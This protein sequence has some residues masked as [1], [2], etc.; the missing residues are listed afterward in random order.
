MSNDFYREIT[1]VDRLIHE[2][3][4][5]A[6]M[7]LLYGVKEADFLFIQRHTGLTKGNLSVHL[8]KL[9]EAGYV[10]IEKRFMGKK[11]QT[12]CRLTPKGRNAFERYLKWSR[13]FS[14]TYSL[15]N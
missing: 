2:P 9:E 11:P 15:D 4:R 3:S 8:S 6:I 1:K 13:N 14:K 7:A 5:L 10:Q 12:L